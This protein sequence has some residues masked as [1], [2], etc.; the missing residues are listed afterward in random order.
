M[1]ERIEAWVAEAL[2]RQTG[3]TLSL[4]RLH[5]ALAHELGPA[6]GTYHHLH[7]RLKQAQGTFVLQERPSPLIDESLWPVDMRQQ[8]AGA[9][10]S[11]GIDLS[12]LVSLNATA[13]D[14]DP[15]VLG[16]LERTLTALRARCGADPAFAADLVNAIAELPN[17]QD[18]LETGRPTTTGLRDP[19][20]TP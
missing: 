4:Q 2:R 14:H 12:P 7:Q 15:G 17:L 13:E 1:M 18:A 19:R 10:R 11:V 9:L 8:Y 20:K 16:V 5:D 3:H 6:A